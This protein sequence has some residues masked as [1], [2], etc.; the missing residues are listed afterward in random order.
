MA[1]TGGKWEVV[2]G[3]SSKKRANFDKKKEK[4]KQNGVLKLEEPNPVPQA[5]T[6]YHAFGKKKHVPES[7]P[8]NPYENNVDD[9]HES[10]KGQEIKKPVIKKKLPPK[11]SKSDRELLEEALKKV[12]LAVMTDVLAKDEAAFP[13]NPSLWL[14]DIASYLHLKLQNVPEKDPVFD[15]QPKDYPS[16]LLTQDMQSFF[17]KVL[18]NSSQTTINLFFE[19]L[20]N[21][22]VSELSKGHSAYAMQAMIQLTVKVCPSITV[23]NLDEYEKMLDA[24]KSRTKE[25]LSIMWALG[26]L[27]TNDQDQGLE[28][29]FRIM[30]PMIQYKQL[31]TFSV[32]Y[33]ENLL[34]TCS[35]ST[36]KTL[37]G[38]EDFLSVMSLTLSSKSP[39]AGNHSLK[40][41]MVSAYP[42]IKALSFSSNPAHVYFP[43]LLG[44]L[45]SIDEMPLEYRTEVLDCL[46]FCLQSDPQC[47]SL[48]MQ[49]YPTS[50]PESSVLI[51]YIVDTWSTRSAKVPKALFQ[52]LI[53]TFQVFNAQQDKG[54]K[55]LAGFEDCVMAC[56]VAEE[57]SKCRSSFFSIKRLFKLVVFI[58]V[59]VICVDLYKHK[60]YQGSKTS[61]YA[62]EYGIE[63]GTIRLYGHAK[64]GFNKGNSWI[65]ENY[66]AYYSQFRE[67]ADPAAAYT[68]E[69]FFIA[70]DYI[71][72]QTEPARKY[73]NKK[74]PE[75]IEK[76]ETE[77]PKYWAVVSG[78]AKYYWNTYWPVVHH[79]LVVVQELFLK[80][81]PPL[82]QRLHE[83]LTTLATRIYELAPEFFDSV[84]AWFDQVGQS[85]TEKVPDVIAVVQEYAVI[86]SNL[87]VNLV[88]NAI[89]WV[90]SLADS[91]EQ[92]E[93]VTKQSTT[94][95][96]PK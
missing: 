73:L 29:W 12:D 19:Y 83:I 79:Y 59:G 35:D 8:H 57:K 7:S 13:N 21:E 87:I 49:L 39:L 94:K 27:P 68:K 9:E 2:Q 33:L 86:A 22:M 34:Q 4:Q 1:S 55:N 70:Y 76:V 50:L 53:S 89:T 81:I 10:D 30:M 16:C 41:K 72:E 44:Y 24:R 58:L 32:L 62:K 18:K 54:S 17:I 69:K 31:A 78:H 95:S 82:I 71:A 11:P 37:L 23:N 90:Q 26:Q 63:Q 67:Y 91:A 56:H 75:I 14:K 42:K 5:Q 36:H 88:N 96:F 85:I 15:G 60:G 80:Y 28:V 92:A 20:M 52:R 25:A 61:R 47:F 38:F 51:Y 43:I 64:N 45:K 65:Q 6:I 77:A 3:K 66:P 84:I 40:R 74:I 46:T 48:W 93:D